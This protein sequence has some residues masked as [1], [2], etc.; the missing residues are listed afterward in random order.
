MKTVMISVGD[1]N[2]EAELN[3]SVTAARIYEALPL[4]GNANVWGDEI[5]FDTPVNI[6]LA[7]DARADV[8]VGELAY[9]PM[10][11]AFCIFFGPTPVSTDGKPRAYSPV[12]VFGEVVGDAARFKAVPNGSII[13]IMKAR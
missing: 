8:K 7:P 1:L 11:P 3:D 13:K 4:E 10:G 6:D 5:Y 12:N 2:I 9:W